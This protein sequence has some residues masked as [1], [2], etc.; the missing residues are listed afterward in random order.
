[1]PTMPPSPYHKPK[2]REKRTRVADEGDDP[3]LNSQKKKPKRS[4]LTGNDDLSTS[5]GLTSVSPGQMVESQ[6]NNDKHVPGISEWSMSSGAGGR[7]T[8]MDPIFAPDGQ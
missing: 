6:Q 1:M 4:R 7:F 2:Q 5:Q 3:E 8:S